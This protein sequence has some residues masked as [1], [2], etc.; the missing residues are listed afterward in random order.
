MLFGPSLH[1]KLSW[2]IPR[3]QH[4]EVWRWCMITRVRIEVARCAS[5]GVSRTRCGC[6][7]LRDRSTVRSL[8][9]ISRCSAA[10]CA[11]LSIVGPS[12]H[13]I[14]WLSV[15]LPPN[16]AEYA[17]WSTVASIETPVTP[18]PIASRLLAPHFED[19]D[20]R[21]ISLAGIDHIHPRKI[22]VALLATEPSGWAVT[23]TVKLANS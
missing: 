3:L 12:L 13:H 20:T 17:R 14:C 9:P 4:V 2:S 7:D 18:V 23:Q 10:L 1:A 16:H 6:A 5:T 15:L 19:S 8:V 21:P 22:L 11:T